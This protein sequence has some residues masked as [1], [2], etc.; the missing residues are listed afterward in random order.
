M[1]ESLWVRCNG[2]PVEQWTPMPVFGALRQTPFRPYKRSKPQGK[3]ALSP[4]ASLLL[5]SAFK[6]M[7][8]STALSHQLPPPEV[9]AL[10]A[11]PQRQ[12]LDVPEI[13]MFYGD[14]TVPDS[15]DE[16]VYRYQFMEEN[17]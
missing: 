11:V 5:F 2:V 4:D 15:E 14:D 10:W 8:L 13:G 9:Q 1:N 3:I 16:N 6:D 7:D 17:N 12:P